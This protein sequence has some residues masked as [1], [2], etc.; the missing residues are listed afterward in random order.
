VG[1][2]TPKLADGG[3]DS[4]AT[5]TDGANALSGALG[6][7]HIG[8]FRSGLRTPMPISKCVFVGGRGVAGGGGVAD[9]IGVRRACVVIPKA[10]S[11]G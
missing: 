7:N 6:P 10:D 5:S 1:P 8:A 4:P 3:P 2:E 11:Q 9:P